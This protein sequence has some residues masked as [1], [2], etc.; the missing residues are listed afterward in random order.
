M[1]PLSDVLSLLK[2]RSYVSAGF[3]AG[4]DWAIQFRDQ[5]NSIKCYAVVSGQCWLSVEGIRDAIRLKTG[6]CFVLP[7]GRP[8]RLASDL[9]L[10]PAEAGPIFS[11][12]R[13]GGGVSYNGGGGFFF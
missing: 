7:S 12:V 1:D 10:T 8:F 11:P 5:Q 13:Y 6:D 2:P 4:G 3:D 9:A